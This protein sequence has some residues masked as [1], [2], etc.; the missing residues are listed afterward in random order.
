MN[1]GRKTKRPK[2]HAISQKRFAKGFG[3]NGIVGAKAVFDQELHGIHSSKYAT[4]RT[5]TLM[6]GSTSGGQ[7]GS[8]NAQCA[9][10][11]LGSRES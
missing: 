2:T 8:S 3:P 10:R 4:A 9:T 1:L 7:V 6:R 5:S 11:R